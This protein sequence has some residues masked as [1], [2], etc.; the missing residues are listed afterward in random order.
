MNLFKRILS[1][2]LPLK[3]KKKLVKSFQT[4]NLNPFTLGFR[5]LVITKMNRILNEDADGNNTFYKLP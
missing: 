3:L 2:I 1:S 5:I 4:S